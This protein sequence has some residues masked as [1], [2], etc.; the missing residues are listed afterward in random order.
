[1]E[2]EKP[3]AGRQTPV[4][5]IGTACRTPGGVTS[6]DEL[7]Q[8]LLDRRDVVADSDPGS[9]WSDDE[10]VIP[11]DLA[12][13]A[14]LRSGS[15]LDGIDLFDPGFFGVPVRDAASVDPQHRLLME[16]TWEALEDAGVPPRSLAGSRTGMFIGI[17]GADY[18]KRFTLADFNVYHGI[19]AVTSGAPGR[20]SY[21]LDVN[22]PSLAVDGACASSLVAVHLA[23][24]S[25]HSGE[26]DLALAGGAT[27]QLEWAGLVGFARA[28]ALSSRGRC[29][30]F[31]A[32]A[33][34]FVRGE[35]CGM[36][37]LKRLADAQRD[38]DR[39]LA[40]IAGTAINHAGRM[41][42]ITQPSRA[43]Q[44]AVIRTAM[45]AAAA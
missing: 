41:Q 11:A 9:R 15:F 17:S 3:G 26:S 6:A 27:V 36:V 30:A 13:P 22:G 44:H 21:I 16:T 23:C 28:G 2:Q 8:L 38:G 14:A 35:G 10:R 45:R 18:A 32:S 31:D 33:D 20:I 34:G 39:V 42:G 7:W 1:M 24:R 25:L 19:S 12:N 43:A 40:V 5:I 37:A 4:A 29:A